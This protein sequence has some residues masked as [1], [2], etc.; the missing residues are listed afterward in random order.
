M[1]RSRLFALVSISLLLIVCAVAGYQLKSIFW[2]DN[3]SEASIRDLRSYLPSIRRTA[4]SNLSQYAADADKVV[5]ALVKALGDSD[6]EVRL[7]A[8]SSLKAFGEYPK[9]AAQT[10]KEMLEHDAD[11][12]IRKGA[13]NLLGS[14]KDRDAIPSLIGALDDQ[15]PAVRLE[16]T[17]ALGRY[18]SSASSPSL[19]EKLIA[20]VS[21]EQSDEFAASGH[22]RCD[23]SRASR[24]ARFGE[25]GASHS[26]V[27]AAGTN[28][29]LR[30]VEPQRRG[31]ESH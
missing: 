16:A 19:I 17:R 18:G 20:R 2:P 25:R 4:A 6:S 14:I 26:C 31:A 13:A 3:T 21:P 7:N 15:D 23:S 1:T 9:V 12:N 22:A 27:R 8:L 10:L 30:P 11:N 28:C 29:C 5:P 24:R